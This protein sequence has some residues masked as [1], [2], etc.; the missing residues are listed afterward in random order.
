[1]SRND[2]NIPQTFIKQFNDF[3]GHKIAKNYSK[4]NIRI[5]RH[6]LNKF[7]R[8]LSDEEVSSLSDVT[9]VTLEEF[10][11]ELVRKDY[12]Q[13]ILKRCVTNVRAFFK[14]LEERG[15]VFVNPAIEFKT[16]FYLPPIL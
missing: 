10:R 6:A 16:P 4:A 1:M 12:S 7:L 5:T 13:A 2:T 8:F 9:P 3:I 11:L 14:Y 15:D